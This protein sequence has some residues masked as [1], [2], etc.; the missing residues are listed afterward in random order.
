MPGL[1]GSDRSRREN[2]GAHSAH[3]SRTRRRRAIRAGTFRTAPAVL[4]GRRVAAANDSLITGSDRTS[5]SGSPTQRVVAKLSAYLQTRP[6]SQSDPQ[7]PPSC[8]SALQPGKQLEPLVENSRTVLNRR[9]SE[10]D[11]GRGRGPGT[12]IT[13]PWRP[14]DFPAPRKRSASRGPHRRP[15]AKDSHRA[16]CHVDRHHIA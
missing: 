13:I 11:I 16:E 12:Q 5:P 14:R 10:V 3:R 4:T 6:D 2:S 7:S 8:V 1:G 15:D 9:T